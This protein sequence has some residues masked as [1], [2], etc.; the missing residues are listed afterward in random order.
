MSVIDKIKGNKA[1]QRLFNIETREVSLVD[2]PAIDE[3]FIEVKSAKGRENDK[4][5]EAMDKKEV[6]AMLQAALAPL[7]EGIKAL[8]AKLEGQEKSVGEQ[9]KANTEAFEK[10]ISAIK[11]E[12]S[13]KHK[14]LVE[15]AGKRFE[16]IENFVTA[17]R[18][19]KINGD[20]AEGTEGSK[21][22]SQLRW[23]S[24]ARR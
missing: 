1:I 8:Q 15:E 17:P 21:G 2:H 16:K 9:L 14:E 24:L 5:E 3:P 6:E 20:G 12:I 23:P 22:A 18:S 13:D 11:S 10:S 4:E 7:A 19:Q